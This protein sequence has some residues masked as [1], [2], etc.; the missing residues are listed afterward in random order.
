[1]VPK[2]KGPVTIY[3]DG[4]SKGNPGHAGVGAIIYRRTS[5]LGVLTKYIGQATNNVAEYT[6]LKSALMKIEPVIRSK[7]GTSLRVLCDSELVAKQLSGVYKI[8]HPELKKLAFTI[9][10]LLSH[11]GSWTIEHIPREENK[12]ADTL[13][14]P[15]IENALKKSKR[16]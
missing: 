1:M 15:A 8:K 6:A 10:K 16:Q 14:S 2:D 4:A 11:Y 13:A 9:Q 7:E 5:V 3:F 12:I